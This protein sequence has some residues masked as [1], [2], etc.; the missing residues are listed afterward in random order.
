MSAATAIVLGAAVRPD[1]TPSAALHRRTLHAIG[2]YRSGAVARL[3]LSGA[4]TGATISEAEAMARLCRAEGLPETA[5]LCED[6]ARST[7]E[8]LA[9]SRACFDGMPPGP[10]VLVTDGYH[11]RRAR[12][13]ARILGLEVVVSSPAAPDLPWPR[14]LR[15]TLREALA[16]LWYAL[17]FA[18]VSARR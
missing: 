11:A 4:A 16:T 13:A 14:R 2:L 15:L 17:R 8:N 10:L 12:L 3:V 1:G 6:R 9:F 5:F 7:I 18:T